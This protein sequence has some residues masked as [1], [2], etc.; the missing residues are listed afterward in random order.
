VV[1]AVDQA[2]RGR[3]GLL[4]ASEGH[5]HVRAP[6]VGQGSPTLGLAGGGCER[7]VRLDKVAG[8]RG[9]G[10]RRIRRHQSC[11]RRRR[12]GMAGSKGL[13]GGRK[14]CQLVGGGALEVAQGGEPRR[15]CLQQLV[16]RGRA[17]DDLLEH[18][19]AL[20]G[21]VR[22]R[23]VQALPDGERGAQL[24]ARLHDRLAVGRRLRVAPLGLREADLLIRVA[25]GLVGGQE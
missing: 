8:H 1:D 11:E 15:L 21:G 7:L 13:D 2:G 23:V 6:R 22:F 12:R 5:D 4:R 18:L 14:R 17:A 10:R 20:L 24:L 9:D 16:R 19:A 3:G 25:H